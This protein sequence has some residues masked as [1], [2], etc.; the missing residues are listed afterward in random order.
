MTTTNR[1]LGGLIPAL[2]LASG[3]LFIPDTANAAA[4]IVINNVN[5]AGIG[6]NDTTPATPVGG[7]NGT[8]LGDQRLI[9]FSYAANL[10]GATLT[11][12]QPIV[13]NA[14]FSALTCTASSAVLGSAG[15]TQVFANFANAPKAD[16]WY[17]YALANKLSGTYQGTAN[18]AQINANFN[19]NL[20]T[21][22]CL[23]GTY[24][25]LG[26]DGNHG[27]N[28]DFVEV[29]LH[30][31]GHGLGF[32]TFTNGTTG[33]FLGSTVTY[34]SVWDH[35][36]YGVTA[37][38]LWKDMTAAE[39]V[40]SATS[41]DKLVW[42]GPIVTAAVP[43]VLRYGLTGATF[44]GPAAGGSAGTVR[45]GE[46]G[47]GAA[48]G[49][50]PF[51][52]EVMPVVEQT[53]G[54]GQGCET[55][56]AANAKAVKG[57]FALISRGICGFVIKVKNAQNAGA[58]GVLIADNVV[59]TAAVPSGLGGS[60]A[61]IM[62]P[63]VRI[64]NTDGIKLLESLKTRS[65]TSSGVFVSLGIVIAQY[66][67][68]DTLGRGQLFAPNP[69]QSGSSVSHFDTAMTRNQLMEPAI[70]GDLTQTVIPPIDMTFPL[71][72]DIGW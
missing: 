14:Q 49:G 9:A 52:G 67:G 26:L 27:A 21:A 36:L 59:E 41:L 56:S 16:T 8:T 50:T 37:G 63:S 60:D 69:F 48:L 54:A 31:M 19:S 62:I 11:S 64:F 58:I 10:W 55:F 1:L 32:Q 12:S 42:T 46:A 34:P 4:T 66:A 24:F 28:T 3:V 71:L 51:V 45:V 30:E 44:T 68:A 57:K 6:F 17:S 53:A 43:N 72:Q 47:Y 13:I 38:K 2:T 22:G 18:A 70:N 33:A 25:Y 5:A 23:T 29:L 20:G 35:Y 39:R 65:R 40:A 61:T 15:A 7:N